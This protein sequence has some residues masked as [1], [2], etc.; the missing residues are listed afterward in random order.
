MARPLR[1]EFS[2]AV[3]HITARGNAQQAIFD[4]DVDR[5]KFL[6]L[7]GREVQQQ[8]WFCYAYCLMDNHYHLLLETHEA[9]LSQGMRRL[10]GNY[11]QSYNFRH[12]RVGHLLQGRYK[13]ILVERESHLMEL[14]RYVV[15]NP[16]RASMVTR[17]EKWPWS[18]YQATVGNVK[19]PDWLAANSLLA[20]F[21]QRKGTAQNAY[22]KFVE[23]GLGRPS[24][25]EKLR[26]QIYLGS[27]K[28]MEMMQKR[29]NNEELTNVS[30]A[31]RQPSRPEPDAIITAV[32]KAYSISKAKV[33]QRNHQ[34]AFN[35]AVYLLRRVGN[36]PLRR[37]AEMAGI[38]A[39]RVSQIQASMQGRSLPEM[40]NK[41]LKLK[42]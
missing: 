20:N 32:S 26:G 18:S 6:H 23:E 34:E 29:V 2:G 17:V 10:N 33:L 11:G 27:E 8:N 7:L 24:P 31:Q 5:E 14:C 37:V 36:I 21:S 16:I 13:S 1:L 42:G 41:L 28:F 30:K 19:S 12:G 3:Y 15:L 9:N 22:A 4:D 40:L 39:G 38:S 35:A 25:W